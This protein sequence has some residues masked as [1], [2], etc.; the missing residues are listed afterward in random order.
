MSFAA[1]SSRIEKIVHGQKARSEFSGVRSQ[2]A[3][4]VAWMVAEQGRRT[5]RKRKAESGRIHPIAGL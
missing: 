2:N 1:Q 4:I 5:N 3:R